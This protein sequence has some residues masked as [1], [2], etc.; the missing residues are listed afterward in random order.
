MVRQSRGR[1]PATKLQAVR[2]QLGRSQDQVVRLMIMRASLLNASVA[3]EPSL[4]VMLSRWENGHDQVTEPVYRR[5]FRE[6]YGRTNDELGFPPELLDEGTEE[7]RDR[8]IVARSIDTATLDLFQNQVNGLRE[9]DL[10]FGSIAV[11]DQLNGLIKQMEEI[12]SFSVSPKHRRRLA[13]I[14]TDA[15][16]L[17]GWTALDSGSQLQAWRYHEDAKVSSREAEAPHLLAH[18]AAQQAVILLDLGDATGAVELLEFARSVANNQ[19]PDLLRSWLA[20]AHA[21]GLASAGRRDDALRAFDQAD[22]DLPANPID[23]EMPFLLLDSGHLARWRGGALTKLGEQDAIEQLEAAVRALETAR[24][25]VRGR[26]AMYVDLAFAYSAAGDREAAIA[27]AQQARRL[28]SQIGSDRQRRRL[29]NL[30]LPGAT[31][32]TI[33]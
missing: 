9:S 2:R 20:A 14:M 11:L 12:R 26:T 13:A 5:L 33:A 15:R 24:A 18:A 16:T 17:A 1:P 8:L 22:E 29:E 32:S 3:S 27:Y 21:E 28:A 30:T 6:I 10:R 19:V 7:L 23:P 4:K 31:G 25:A